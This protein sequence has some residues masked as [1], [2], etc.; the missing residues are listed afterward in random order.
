SGARLAL[1]W[2]DA[3]QSHR[4]WSSALPLVA[5]SGLPAHHARRGAVRHAQ[6]HLSDPRYLR[7]TAPLSRAG[8]SAHFQTQ[9]AGLASR[10]LLVFGHTLER[11]Y[12]PEVLRLPL[13]GGGRQ[14]V[15][16]GTRRA[17]RLP[18]ALG[19]GDYA[20]ACIGLC[21]LRLPASAALPAPVRPADG[22]FAAV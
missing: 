4:Q 2:R 17:G 12:D 1:D 19:R 21:R 13:A 9:P 22:S 10:V 14:L 20:L 8:D 11:A 6:S 18:P 5:A 15:L 16:E 7:S 3:F